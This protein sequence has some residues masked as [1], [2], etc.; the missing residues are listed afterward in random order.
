MLEDLVDI[1][2][3]YMPEKPMRGILA[4]RIPRAPQVRKVS[5]RTGHV[6]QGNV[7]FREVDSAL[8]DTEHRLQAMDA[9]GIRLQAVSA[10]PVTLDFL[11]PSQDYA[12]YCRWINSNLAQ[13]IASAKGRLVGFGIVPFEDSQECITALDHIEELGLIGI[14][15]GTRIG[16]KDL[17]DPKFDYF[18]AEV[19]RR[20]LRLLVH[21]LDGGKNIIRREGFL[22]DFGL[23]MTTDTALAATSL[24][25]GGVLAQYPDLKIC[26]SHG[27]GTFTT[28][29]PRLRLGAPIADTH[30]ARKTDDLVSKLF[31]D[32]L[33]FDPQL[34][35]ALINRYGEEQ[36]LF[37]T[38]F[39]FIPGQPASGIADLHSAKDL[40]GESIT[41]K[42][43]SENALRFLGLQDSPP[44]STSNSQHI[45]HSL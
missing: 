23:G 11:A 18:F 19:E 8:W 22:H 35:P 41:N 3:H 28:S 20:G 12:T 36:V 25:F 32:S 24:V 16:G 38:D 9:A 6:M 45:Q 2:A 31:V 21:P 1:H 15:I 10:M 13:D 33:V 4:A 29:Y 30:E 37:G 42:I 5:E 34:I 44:S 39:P 14:E 7:V 26:M 27:C 40:V 43:C 17:D